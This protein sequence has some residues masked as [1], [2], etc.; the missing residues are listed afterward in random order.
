MNLQTTI[1]NFEIV[2]DKANEYFITLAGLLN[3]IPYSLSVNWKKNLGIIN[4]N[5]KYS[6]F[7]LP[8]VR[9]G[10]GTIIEAHTN[11]VICYSF[12]VIMNPEDTSK[13]EFE[14]NWGDYSIE[15]LVDGA[16]IR[17]Y[18]YNEKWNIATLKCIEASDAYWSSNKSFKELFDEA[19]LESGLNYDVLNKNYCYTFII[20]HPSNHMIVKYD[21]RSIVHLNTVDLQTCRLVEHDIGIESVIHESFDSYEEFIKINNTKTESPLVETSLIGYILTNTK[22]GAKTKFENPSYAL[23]RKMKGNVPNICYQ[24]LSLMREDWENGNTDNKTNFLKFFPQYANDYVYTEERFNKT[25]GFIYKCYLNLYN[26]NRHNQLDFV[27]QHTI[28][29]L[30]LISQEH[31]K[32]NLSF[33]NMCKYLKSLTCERLSNILKIPIIFK[34]NKHKKTFPKTNNNKFNQGFDWQ[35]NKNLTV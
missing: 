32:G 14:T 20:R 21:K 31:Y 33:N 15:R 29:E 22:T 18:Y 13:E 24:I 9:E 19:S 23:A 35:L 2:E 30:Y 17:V 28:N 4:S 3:K 26:G 27:L 5:R 12:N 25:S 16:V 34:K 11:K 8:E 6:D 10:N 7:T 1:N